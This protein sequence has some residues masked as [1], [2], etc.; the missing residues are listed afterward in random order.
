LTSNEPI[1][2]ELFSV[3]RLEQHA[4]TLA[5]AQH[6][7][8]RPEAGYGMR[9]RL[10]D[11]AR[12]LLHAYQALAD[13]TRGDRPISPAAEWL[14]DNFHI[15]DEQIREIKEDLPPS[16]YREL[17]KLAE[18]HLQGYPR[19]FG[20]AWAFVAHTDSR[21]ESHALTRFVN[22]Y[23]RVQPLTIGELWAIAITL[24]I[25]LVENLRRIAE[26]LARNRQ[27]RLD[28]DRLADRL[29][30]VSGK[31]PEPV[32]SILRSLEGREL[33]PAF[34][35]QLDHR[36]RDQD[37][38]VAPMLAW[39]D[40][41]LAE[42]G[43]NRE[44][45]VQEELRI[46]GAMNVTVRNII[47]SMRQI[48]MVDW[49]ELFERMS[50][51]DATLKA[52][53][54]FG[55]MD[56]ATRDSYR[57]AIEEL[58]RGSKRS[59]LDVATKAVEAAKRAARRAP[60][61]RLSDRERD[62][63]YYLI[64]KGR[65]A[66][67]QEIGFRAPRSEWLSRLRPGA[68]TAFYLG[69]IALMTAVI[70]ALAVSA[71]ANAG[72]RG[73]PLA[74]LA[75][76][77][78][79][80]ASDAAISVVNRV[81]VSRFGPALLPAMDLSAGVPSHL[82]TLVAMPVLLTSRTQVEQLVQQ[83][84][85]HYLASSDGDTY[86]ALLS[87]WTD[88]DEESAPD[89]TELLEAARDAILELNRRHGTVAAPERFFLLHRRR[90]WNPGERKWIGWERKRGKLHELNRLL[91]GATD[92]TFLPEDGEPPHVPA[93]VRY[94]ITL[95]A[96]TRLPREAAKKLIGKMAHPLNRPL[97]DRMAGRVVEGHAILQPRVTPSM[98]VGREGSL[99]QL[100]F[101]EPRGL[102]PYAFAV[103]D[104]YQ[105]LF[106]EGSYCGKGIYDVDVF[107]VAL[108]GRIPDD[109]VLSHDLLEGS[110]ARAGLVSDIEVVE[111]FPARYEVAA[112]RQH[113]WVR[114][115]WQ[116]L[117]W[118]L[119]WGRDRKGRPRRV[120][121]GICRWK[122]VDNL[123]RS[124]LPPV[125]LAALISGWFLPLGAA[126]VWTSFIVA[127]FALPSLLPWFAG[128]IPRRPGISKRSHF[129][130][131]G[132]DLIIAIAQVTFQITFLAHQAYV[133]AD[134]ILRTLFRLVI[135]R[136]RLLEWV[137][138]AQ[139]S[140]L[141]R[142]DAQRFR[143]QL[144]SSAV[145]ALLLFVALRFGGAD[146][147]MIALPFLTLWTFSPLVAR[148]VSYS[149][150]Q[151]GSLPIEDEGAQELR[152]IARR[153]WRFFEGFLTAADHMLPPDN[154]QEDPK[155]VVARRTSPT[156]IG[157]CLLT[158][159]S[160]R[161]FGWIGTL[162]AVARLEGTLK[163]MKTME[164]FRGHFYNW[165]ATEDLRPLYPRYVSTVDS[166]N[167]AGHLLVL[168]QACR[169]M[170]RSPAT[171][172]RRIAGIRDTVDLAA[173]SL[174][175]LVE[176]FPRPPSAAKRLAAALDEIRTL[177]QAP[178]GDPA[179][180]AIHLTN[181]KRAAE[182]AA[183]I[184]RA[185]A[186]E[187]RAP[188]GG[189]LLD[190]M[191]S[192]AA[193]LS[194]HARDFE[195][196]TPRRLAHAPSTRSG[197]VP[198]ETW[199]GG[200]EPARGPDVQ[201]LQRR[202]DVVAPALAGIVAGEAAVA[203][204]P[205]AMLAPRLHAL[206]EAA[207][208]MFDAMVFDFLYEPERQLFAIGYRVE[209]AALDPN[210]YDLL[211]SEARLASFIAI[212]KEEVPAKHWF[213]LGRTLA[214]IGRGSALISWSGSM[215]EY[216]MPS[217]VMRAP[218]GSIIERTNELVVRR[219]IKY[220][221]ELG[222]PWGISESQFN[223]RDIEGTY[224]YSSFGVPDL[225]Y[226][227]G[228]GE[229]AVIAPYAAALAAMVD[230]QAAA[231]NFRRMAKEGARGRFGWYE[232]LDY[233]PSRVPEGAKVGIV[234]AYMAHH[235]AMSIVAILNALTGGMMRRRF[236]AEP[237]IR[238]TELLLQERMPRDIAVARPPAEAVPAAE[239]IEYLAPEIQRR[240]SSPHSQIP[241]THILSN[242]TY[243]VMLT[244]AGS[245]YTRWRNIDVTRWREDST[246]DNWGSY[247]YLRDTRSGE[248]WSAG[249]QPI[250]IEP[251][252]YEVAFS[253]SRAEFTRQ[254]G[255]LKTT[256]EVA[257]SCEHDTDVRRVCITNLGTRSREIE[258][259]SFAELALVPHADDAVHPAFAKLFVETDFVGG[260]SVLL[261][262]R[263][264]KS[265]DEPEI[266]VA[267]LATIEGDKSGTIQFETD[268]ARF[269]GRGQSVRSPISVTEGWPLTNTAGCVL[270]PIFSLR[271]RV[272][273]PRGETVRVSFWTLIAES[274]QDALDLADKHLEPTACERVNTL[275]W[276]HAQG[277][278]H[279]LGIGP[280]EAHL[281][282]RLAN[283][284]LFSDP[285]LRPPVETLKRGGRK[286][287]A[288]WAHGISGDLPIVLLRIDDVGDLSI[289]RQLLRAF[290]YWRLKRLAVDVV[291]LN[292][293]ATS[294]L[295]DL[296][297]AIDG[298]VRP[299]QTRPKSE[300]DDVRGS[301]HVLRADLVP[302]E[303]CTLL[304]AV[305]RI[306]L[307]SRRGTL[308]EQVSRLE[309]ARLPVLFSPPHP[310][311]PMV[312][313]ALPR[314]RPQLEFFNGL[315]GF[316][317]RGR[318]Y[319]TLLDQGHCTPAPWLN[320]IANPTFGFQVSTDGSGFTW[321]QNSQQNR[322]TPWSNDP[323]GDPTGEAIFLRDDDSGDVW[324]P[325]I[326]PIR[327]ENGSYTIRH[328]QGYSRFEH[329]SHGIAA[330]LLQFV[331]VD[332]P[333]K[334]S[335]LKITNNSRRARNISLT[336]YVEWVLGTVREASAPFIVTAID[337]ET[338]AMFARNP[339]SNESG[340]RVSF[341]DLDGRQSSWTGDR[342]EFIGRNSTLGRPTGL[343]R[344]TSLSNRTGAALD[345]CGALQ[346]TFRLQP[347][348]AID[349]VVLLGQA[350]TA[351]AAQAL[352]AK[353]RTAD[354]NAVFDRVAKFWD[355][356]LGK[357][358]IKTPDRALDILF[359]RWLGYQT[360]ACRV[361]ARSGFYQSSGA[362]GF[363]DQLQDSTSLTIVSPETARSHLLRAA[364]RQFV[365]GD[366]QHWW[367]PET[368]RGV[369][370]R[371]SDDRIWLPFVAAH[372][373]ESTGD[374]KCL[375]ELVPF[376]EG[377]SL[378]EGE[379]EVFFQP[380]VSDVRASLYEH[381]ARAL[382][383]SL[384]VGAH[385]LPLIGTGDWNDGMNHVG[386]DGKG[387]SV[388]LGWF[389]HA[390]LMAFA[391]IAEERGE[392]ARAAQWRQHGQAL[393][394]ALD[395]AWDGD[396]YVRAYFGDGTPLGSV[397]NTECRIDSIAQS[398]SVISRAGE[399][400]RTQRAMAAVEKYLLR[401]DEGLMLLF[402]PPFD[403]A[404]PNPGYIKG[405]P[406]GIRENGGQYTH[407]ALWAALAYGML[408]DG[409]RLGELMWLLNP[410]HHAN[411]NAA[412]HR[413]KV[414]PYIVAADVYGAPPH[415]GRGGWTWYTGSAGWMYRVALETLLG[416]KV[417]GLTVHLDPCIPRHW[418]GFD[419][420]F[421]HG[422]A[423]YD[424]AVENPSR[425]NRGV[426]AA[427]LDGVALPLKPLILPLAD[428][429]KEHS[430]R[431]VLG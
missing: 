20:V 397:T 184:A 11:N 90:V 89:D 85:V 425:I 414:E 267:H 329:E 429:G 328:G 326:A 300:R 199:D 284:I 381:C 113:R 39:L 419:I 161:D 240:Y 6:V 44:H 219:Q 141:F 212:A 22:A 216:L 317:E 222:V 135:S 231:E 254:D 314:S 217:L 249:Y 174:K 271:C 288:L 63:G 37:A 49:T 372:Y 234:R 258:L 402:T 427:E 374:R 5:A 154:Y 56:F 191:D 286:I 24:R 319:V 268:R 308:F 230:P 177:L 200:S 188:K 194:S 129:R 172:S 195:V 400:A 270:D 269:L 422:T 31:K 58:A 279:H 294:Y 373:V 366:V 359:N 86:F 84:E 346:T 313:A 309:Q 57:R 148:W 100:V 203:D 142:D 160:A 298:L 418:P 14:L 21:F 108:E 407:A 416:F 164:R 411:T 152:F 150:P 91:R 32:L 321:A 18:G 15:V 340:G 389:L 149:P 192:L 307:V 337:A 189:E 404:Q 421:R 410:I 315:G 127:T 165:Y 95:D 370:T 394:D 126:E 13:D 35:V 233:T 201:V 7:T 353:Y 1:R 118:I 383:S 136:R 278:F 146:G 33:T 415:V 280:E 65:E 193:C 276:T 264:R 364:S 157:L 36:L 42:K 417:H 45:I 351:S 324:S 297:G 259:T 3:E 27:A 341:L 283:R 55:G 167:L 183:A 303:V 408:G 330:D 339:V 2:A 365:E 257:V 41:A 229:D 310:P 101:S 110:F 64:A 361:W 290:E 171:V 261:A 213:K 285:T 380:A 246:C 367:L 98:P 70:D 243:A 53:S 256:M 232:A 323:T 71:V 17:P 54:E 145:F 25:T 73:W 134:A 46:Q 369:R 43:T 26:A 158:I 92:T 413:Y 208:E 186:D 197:Y 178:D 124:L 105:D 67:E 28:A 302:L 40:G 187:V 210:C 312:V 34:A 306:V 277:Q 238:A 121:S 406:P 132:K 262:T 237:I 155:G 253:E 350:E 235:Q 405:Y 387:E 377:Q 119:G 10:H 190:W 106:Q 23:Q 198:R 423:S 173:E 430:V 385:G 263:R 131:L 311:A 138:A 371:V 379:R 114:G 293:R 260:A 120:L 265:D 244:S 103:S 275:A 128:L 296:Q 116:L 242:G 122:M 143:R 29:L 99:L 88:A 363:R 159:L 401:R 79:I 431:V 72:L 345:P 115:D 327:V 386:D 182:G 348:G 107:E 69:L 322:I 299:I 428:D 179:E 220:G 180:F 144:A 287:S 409:D 342:A 209:D 291:I 225:G 169:E 392:Q 295:Q 66:F 211:A 206:A 170:A 215:F 47:T 273:V 59:E 368:G 320:V 61:G 403:K 16:Y 207:E 331:P 214:P 50:L 75:L 426:L 123:R 251:D 97:L 352:V 48:S 241:R 384:Q 81:V 354:L 335:V 224:Q 156:N 388:W 176:D 362:Y 316:A 205:A 281:F 333:V 357:V 60:G 391:P 274:R 227:R 349:I 250:G 181:L 343:L 376:L 82:R 424:I 395:R 360:L 163:T 19:V 223:A 266:W 221:A 51:V 378:R 247:I 382:D 175:E 74:G 9:A 292:E 332:D 334:I 338:G 147:E 166:G 202:P 393:K 109:T 236:H 185:L 87:D 325:T 248:V 78:L 4:E 112:A 226:K 93:G 30:G 151:S 245:G 133:M 96:D 218:A 104:V 130:D 196:T 318:E 68:R 344:G 125:A 140:R 12:V 62:P 168:K 255:T 162:D 137:T 111:D 8:A 83:L 153:N 375:D 76:L 398:W 301:V 412:V 102:D 282:Q 94:V 52:D 38:A 139:T 420:R 336:A 355:D 289:V 252:F 80:P 272:R 390:A 399:A 347:G 204:D 358:Q 304:Y 305:A 396:W 356:R 239:R 117:P 228:L 77:G